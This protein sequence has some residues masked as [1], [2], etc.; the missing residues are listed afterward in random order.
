MRILDPTCSNRSIWFDKNNPHVIHCDK[1]VEKVEFADGRDFYIEPDIQTDFTFMPFPD[2][3]F[4]M[5]VFDPPHLMNL[6]INSMLAKRY[7]KLFANWRDVI[8][9]GF[10]ESWRVL[11]TGGTL[12]FKWG[13]RDIP[14]REVLELAPPPLCGQTGAVQKTKWICFVK[15][16]DK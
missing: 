5:V 7:G 13:D 14:L 10:D 16:A 4:D 15:W 3:I 9:G 8:K 1:R 11:K 2:E 12:I 6:G